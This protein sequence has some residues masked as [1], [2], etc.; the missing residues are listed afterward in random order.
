MSSSVTDASRALLMLRPRRRGAVRDW[1]TSGLSYPQPLCR[2]TSRR[3][4]LRAFRR[5]ARAALHLVVVVEH[6]L[7]RREAIVDRL[8]NDGVHDRARP[9]EGL[10]I[11]LAL[12]RVDDRRRV[13][14]SQ[15]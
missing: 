8:L 12:C 2:P 11:A 9:L 3:R 6:L 15:Q 13:A 14:R 1:P 5:S 4:D 10:V 7:D